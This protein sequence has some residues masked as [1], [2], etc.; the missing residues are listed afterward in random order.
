M[1]TQMNIIDM[2]C[3]LFAFRCESPALIEGTECRTISHTILYFPVVI[4]VSLP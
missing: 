1:A 3:N 2:H 4:S